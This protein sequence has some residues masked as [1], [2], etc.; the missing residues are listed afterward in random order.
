MTRRRV[1]VTGLG[2]VAPNG[3]G[4]EKFWEAL[5]AGRS[6]IRAI[7]SF[8]ASK[9]KSRIAGEIDFDPEAH[10]SAK[11]AKRSA[12]YARLAI[13]AGLEALE[14]SKIGTLVGE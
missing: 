10:M 8:D 14:H 2:V 1:V 12:R 9:H 5:I 4:V 3:I 7:Q 13:A 6:G 11:V